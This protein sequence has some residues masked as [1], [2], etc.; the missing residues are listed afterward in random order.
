MAELLEPN[1]IFFTAFEPKVK[2]RF[3]MYIDGI[4]SY[5]IKT[6]KRPS[7]TLNTNVIEHININRK[8]KG[9]KTDWED[10][11]ITLYDPIAPSGA[12]AVMEW[13]RLSHE[14]VSGRDGYAD[15]YKKDITISVIGPV[16]DK[17]EEWVLKGAFV[18]KADFG[19]LDWEEGG[20]QMIALT[21][22]FDYAILEF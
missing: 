7:V 11:D 22:S 12:Q 21:I 4:P 10:I 17:V 18:N 20:I 5:I 19:E 2:N 6:S 9:G 15:F 1:E 3:V 8:I 13:V 14:S 16:G